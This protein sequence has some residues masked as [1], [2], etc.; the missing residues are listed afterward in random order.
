MGRCR[1]GRQ[2]LTPAGG[3]ACTLAC[4]QSGLPEP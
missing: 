1:E 2:G 4:L 3:T